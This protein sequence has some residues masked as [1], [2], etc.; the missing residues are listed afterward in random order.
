MSR[1]AAGLV[2][3]V[4]VAGACGHARAPA[5]ANLESARERHLLVADGVRVHATR[6]DA[7]LVELAAANVD[8]GAAA[9]ADDDDGVRAQTQARLR[10]RH[11]SAGPSFTVVVEL[12]QRPHDGGK[13]ADPATWWFGLR[14]RERGRC[15]ATEFVRPREVEL[16][17]IDRHPT[18]NGDADLRLSF[19]VTFAGKPGRDACLVV[20]NAATLGRRTLLGRHVARHGAALRW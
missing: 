16:V 5:G 4:L 1:G 2:G 13:L 12:A 20:G 3:L 15:H 11:V 9:K 8:D 7:T 19:D 17:A 6:W 18:Q 10:A 14:A